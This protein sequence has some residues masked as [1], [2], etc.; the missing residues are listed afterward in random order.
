MQYNTCFWALV[1]DGKSPEE[2]QAVLKVM[3]THAVL[4]NTL[5][6]FEEFGFATVQCGDADSE[7]AWTI[8]GHAL[9]CLKRIMQAA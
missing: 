8:S 4:Q 7:S 1:K 3:R 2:A 9:R 6:L 5:F